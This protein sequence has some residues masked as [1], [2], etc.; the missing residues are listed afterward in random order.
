MRAA[1]SRADGVE[2]QG[3]MVGRRKGGR[4]GEQRRA[5][6]RRGEVGEDQDGDYREPVMDMIQYEQGTA[7]PLNC[8]PVQGG[9]K[10]VREGREL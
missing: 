5:E 6:E 2:Q 7:R 10:S 8:V 1:M 4:W 3:G 9:E